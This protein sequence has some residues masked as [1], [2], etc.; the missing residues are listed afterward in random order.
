MPLAFA[1]L[2]GTSVVLGCPIQDEPAGPPTGARGRCREASLA[3]VDA[4]RPPGDMAR[5]DARRDLGDG[6]RGRR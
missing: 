6:A 3:W 2:L 5:L 1:V 4:D